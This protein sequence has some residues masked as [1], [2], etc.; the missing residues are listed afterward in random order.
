MFKY[1]QRKKLANAYKF[2]IKM[3]SDKKQTERIPKK[4]IVLPHS[5]Y[6]V[7]FSAP[8]SNELDDILDNLSIH[9]SYPCWEYLSGFNDAFGVLS[10]KQQ[11]QRKHDVMPGIQAL[12]F[13]R[14]QRAIKFSDIFTNTEIC[15]EVQRRVSTYIN[16]HG[17]NKV[18][19]DDR[20]FKCINREIKSRMEF[21]DMTGEYR[22]KILKWCYADRCDLISDAREMLIKDILTYENS[23]LPGPFAKSIHGA[24][25]CVAMTVIHESD[26]NFIFDEALYGIEKRNAG[27]R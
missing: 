9:T 2:G 14:F 15:A 1:S 8:E 12:R 10:F 4:E 27:P 25:I 22:E 3:P 11:L 7:S 18:N 24:V 13:Q 5:G 16:V 17:L 26:Q 21:F 23:D 20:F 6:K 19:Y